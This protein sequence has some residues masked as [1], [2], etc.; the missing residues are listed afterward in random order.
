MSDRPVIFSATMVR[1]LLAGRKTQTRRLANSPLRR[2]AVG[3]RLWV[4]EAWRSADAYDDLAPSELGGEEGVWYAAD[5]ASERHLGSR[6]GRQRASMHM[7]RWASRLKLVVEAVK[8]EP[9]QVIS[10][11]DSWA[12]GVCQAVEDSG[13]ASFGS[14]PDEMRQMIVTSIIGGGRQAYH[15][16]WDQF[17]TRAGE[18]WKDNPDV[19]ALTFRVARGNIDQMQA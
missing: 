3:D 5:R 11:G 7:P 9:L 14:C 19:V 4:R 13:R 8:V 16:L 17:H 10:E 15:W 1:A 6:P 2:C 12:E 18:R